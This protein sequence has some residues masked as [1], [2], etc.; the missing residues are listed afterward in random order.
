CLIHLLFTVLSLPVPFSASLLL[1]RLGFPPASP[2]CACECPLSAHPLSLCPPVSLSSSVSP[3]HALPLS[4]SL[5]L[6]LSLSLIVLR[7]SSAW[8]SGDNM[9]H[10][11]IIQQKRG[12]TCFSWLSPC[13]LL[14]LLEG[15]TGQGPCP[16]AENPSVFLWHC[17][18]K[19]ERGFRES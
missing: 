8:P 5:F 6:R 2:L 13:L 7:H 11:Q 3:S 14:P 19:A 17:L 16:A 18:V 1:L 9:F 12:G 4:F 10:R 15:K